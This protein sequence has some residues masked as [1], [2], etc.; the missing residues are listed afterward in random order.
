[1]A[2]WMLRRL[3]KVL[4]LRFVHEAVRAKYCQDNGRPSIDPE[5]VIRLFLLQTF[6]GH[7][8]IRQLMRGVQVNLAYRW[9]FGHP[10]FTSQSRPILSFPSS[11][12]STS[13]RTRQR[14]DGDAMGLPL[15]RI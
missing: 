5:V 1:M 8:S 4:D 7:A 6:Y 12:E 10:V 3:D 13:T 15:T 14:T 11:R 2:G 9:F